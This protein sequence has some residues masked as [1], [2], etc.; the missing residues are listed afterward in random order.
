MS[1][2]DFITWIKKQ[3]K[4]KKPVLVGIGDDS[5]VIDVCNIKSFVISTDTLL[6]GTHFEQKKCTPKQIG[7]KAITSSISD[8]AAMGCKPVYVLISIS[9]PSSSSKDYCKQIYN[10]FLDITN[11][12]DV[13]II[14]GDIVSGDCPLNINVTIIGTAVE[15]KPVLRSGAK[16]GDIIMVTGE[17][18]GSILGKHL[19]FAPRVDEGIML[20]KEF[21]VNSMIDISDGLLIDLHHIIKESNVGA[22][23]DEQC[24][25]VSKAAIKLSKT[26]KK[27]PISHAMTDGEDYE[28][29]FTVSKTNAVK[30]ARSKM[31]DIHLSKIG[32]IQNRKGLF[33]KG[34]NGGKSL[35]SP[36]GYEH[37]AS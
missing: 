4:C 29:L 36:K 13:Q 32:C 14:G 7:R 33:V 23:I 1:E 21:H 2:L 26:T 15:L 17:L 34:I 25:P 11:K 37:L 5:A 35:V 22:V 3:S 12:Y 31:F 18:G 8:I 27:S 30:I 20:N 19:R 9:F 28:L 24:I 16:P 10:G 6:D